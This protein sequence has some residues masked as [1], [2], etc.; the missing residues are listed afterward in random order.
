M[1]GDRGAHGGTNVSLPPQVANYFKHNGK[2]TSPAHTDRNLKRAKRKRN[3]VSD[4]DHAGASLLHAAGRLSIRKT[5][6]K[7]EDMKLNSFL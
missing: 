6:F 4:Y 7:R 1:D 3:D 2:T 5:N